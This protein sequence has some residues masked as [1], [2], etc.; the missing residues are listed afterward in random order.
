M[1]EPL[2]A[3]QFFRKLQ[4]LKIHTRKAYLGSRQGIHRS[5]RRG[6]GLEFADYRVYTPG[7]DFRHIDWGAYAR[8]DRLYVRQFRE[9]QDLNVIVILDASASMAYPEGSG[10]FVTA[11]DLALALGYVAMS[12]GDSVMFSILGRENT[13]RFRGARALSRA[14]KALASVEPEGSF[15]FVEE[16]RAALARQKIPGRCFLISDFMMPVEQTIAA[17]DLLR[18]RNF[19][20]SIIQVLA[21]EELRLDTAN[22]PPVVVDAETNETVELALSRASVQEYAALLAAHIAALERY[23]AKSGISHVLVSSAEPV[24]D[25]VL[26]KFP[27]VGLLK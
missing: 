14:V 4:Q 21:P 17:L 6:H 22:T 3:P 7:D 12:D 18:G 5:L 19:D 16:V 25:I 9:E 13:P 24:Q 20:V 11:R 26:T 27:A 23:C 10:K 2:F 1:A 8:T 15:N